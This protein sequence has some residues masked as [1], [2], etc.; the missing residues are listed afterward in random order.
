ML[1]AI[2]ILDRPGMAETRRT[3]RA[4]HIAY[5]QDHA[6]ALVLA[7]PVMDVEGGSIGSVRIVDVADRAAAERMVAEDPFA[8]A[9]CFGEI[10]IDPYRI[11][12]K[13]GKLAE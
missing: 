3:V 2:R 6:A 12:F 7:G 1:F 8:K 10:R 9:S 13:D 4:A 5:L 11:V